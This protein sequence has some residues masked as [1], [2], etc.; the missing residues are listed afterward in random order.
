MNLRSSLEATPLHFAVINRQ[1][2]NVELLIKF[3]AD[4]DAVDKEGRTPLHI[5]V[6]RLCTQ[7]QQ[8]SLLRSQTKDEAEEVSLE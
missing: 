2:K 3:S 8:I 7:F 4:V 1:I 6:I 5:A